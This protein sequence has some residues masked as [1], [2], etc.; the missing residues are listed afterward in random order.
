P[1]SWQN[2]ESEALAFPHLGQLAFWEAPHSAQNFASGDTDFP[3]WLQN[4]PPACICAAGA[5]CSALDWVR[6]SVMAPAICCP[7]AMPTPIPVNPPAP[8]E[9]AAS[10]IA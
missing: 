8:P 2:R 1:H 10:G 6:P 4:F 7:I 9:R 3:H 5:A